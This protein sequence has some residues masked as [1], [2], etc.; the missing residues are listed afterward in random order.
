VLIVTNSTAAI[1]TLGTVGSLA[2]AGSPDA[3]A[4]LNSGFNEKQAPS[5]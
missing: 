5:T 2:E 4:L 1:N 3:R